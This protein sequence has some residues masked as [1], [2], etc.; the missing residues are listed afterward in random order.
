MGAKGLQT[1][2]GNWFN[3]L[4]L[5]LY[6]FRTSS[7]AVH[8]AKSY[9]SQWSGSKTHPVQV[10]GDMG[11]YL[12]TEAKEIGLGAFN[13]KDLIAATFKKQKDKGYFAVFYFSPMAGVFFSVNSSVC[14]SVCLSFCLTVYL[15]VCLSVLSLNLLLARLSVHLSICLRPTCLSLSVGLSCRSDCLQQ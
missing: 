4:D 1:F 7:E 6:L 9:T 12:M 5:F 11:H 10:S 13:R 8:F 2:L 3:L 14:L 15:T